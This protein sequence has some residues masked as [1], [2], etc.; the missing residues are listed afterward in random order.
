MIYK[1]IISIYK[2]DRK[3]FMKEF[4]DNDYDY[5]NIEDILIVEDAKGEDE[6]FPFSVY[7]RMKGD[8]HYISF[9][10]A[11]YTLEEVMKRYEED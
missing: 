3:E 1:N 5:D 10:S 7:V 11:E 6:D 2:M 8:S 4:G 9:A